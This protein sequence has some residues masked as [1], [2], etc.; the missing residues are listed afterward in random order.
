MQ[1]WRYH[2][3]YYLRSRRAAENDPFIESAEKANETIH[4]VPYPDAYLVDHFHFLK[5][6]PAWLPGAKFKRDASEWRKLTVDSI[7]KPFDALK[8][9]MARGTATPSFAYNLLQ[10][11]G[12]K[13]TKDLYTDTNMRNVSATAYTKPGLKQATHNQTQILLGLCVLTLLSH[14]DKMKKIQDEIDLLTNGSRLP[15][16]SDEE[17]VPYLHAFI[18]ETWS[19]VPL[20][21][22]HQLAVDDEYKGY[23]LPAKSMIIPNTWAIMHNEKVFAEPH[24]FNPDRFLT[25]DNL[26]E[27]NAHYAASWGF[28]RRICPGRFLATGTL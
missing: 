26:K 12:N 27:I 24:T 3:V 18:E 16:F 11:A 19:F 15:E 1:C 6:V 25:G 13:E 7:N 21:V 20:S 17:N 9:E 28:G 10:K 8:A 2:S 5:H 4:N 22:P 23:F 14:P